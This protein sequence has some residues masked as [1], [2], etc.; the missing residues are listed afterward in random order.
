MVM[1]CIYG[2]GGRPVTTAMDGDSS[3]PMSP[4]ICYPAD[5]HGDDLESR[6][7]AGEGQ[8]CMP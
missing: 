3:L 5:Y 1:I 4:I 7:R 8:F 6:G 2:R